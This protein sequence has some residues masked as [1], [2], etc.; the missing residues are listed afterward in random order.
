[1]VKIMYDDFE[2]SVLDEG[3]QTRWFKITTGVKQGCVMSGFLFLLTV[4]WTMRRTTERHRNGI[5]WDFT[6][7]LEDLDFADDIVLVSS[8]YDHIQNK[9]NRLVDNAGR[10]GLKLTAQKCKVMR[11]NTRREDK[12]MIGREEVEECRRVCIFGCNCDKRGWWHRRHQE[13]SK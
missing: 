2:C 12:V 6:S 10:V 1:M 8:K 5:R 13:T 11:M 3:E 7:T 9:T 4:D